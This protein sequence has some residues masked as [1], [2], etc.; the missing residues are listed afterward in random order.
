MPKKIIFFIQILDI[1][2]YINLKSSGFDSDQL[3]VHDDP[4]LILSSSILFRVV[5]QEFWYSLPTK[6][7]LIY[8]T[9][10]R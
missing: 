1:F 9:T 5:N 3:V 4:K 7:Y 6:N 8:Y 2:A 10:L